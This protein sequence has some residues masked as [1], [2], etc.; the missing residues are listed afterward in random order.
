MLLSRFFYILIFTGEKY[1]NYKKKIEAGY[2]NTASL[3]HII[4]HQNNTVIYVTR[5]NIKS[6]ETI[7]DYDLTIAPL[8]DNSSPTQ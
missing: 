8:V 5:E 4:V 7:H 2:I 3:E 1:Q 6:R